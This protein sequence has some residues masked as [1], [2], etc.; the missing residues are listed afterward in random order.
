MEKDII[1]YKDKKEL[2]SSENIDLQD[3]IKLI[4]LKGIDKAGY[5]TYIQMGDTKILA[6]EF[7]D[8]LELNSTAMEINLYEKG[9]RIT[10][11][12]KGHGFGMSLSY[13]K[14]LARNGSQWQDILK[15]FYDVTISDY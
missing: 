5:V 13:A 7:A 14:E 4:E 9:I 6:E 1:V 10:T 15:K 12:G 2:L 8:A 3:L 11:K